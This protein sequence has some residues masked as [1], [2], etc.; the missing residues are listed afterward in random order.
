MSYPPP[1]GPD[2]AGGTP[3]P[4]PPSSPYG[5]A[6]PPPPPPPPYGGPPP[7]YQPAPGGYYGSPAPK[8]NQKALWAMILGIVGLVCCSPLAIA[9]LVLGIIA[10]EEIDESHGTQSGRGQAQAGFVLGI[11]GCVLMVIGVI[12]FASGGLSTSDF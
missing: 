2:D 1:P 10:K 8:G 5:S 12:A 3:P 4:V 7:G 9:A 11:I 6:P